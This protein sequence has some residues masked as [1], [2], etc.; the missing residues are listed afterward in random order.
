VS[1]RILKE[2]VIRDTIRSVAITRKIHD[3]YSISTLSLMTREKVF[4]REIAGSVEAMDVVR[5]ILKFLSCF[6][7]N[8]WN[9]QNFISI[10]STFL[11]IKGYSSKFGLNSCGKNSYFVN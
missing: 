7:F 8:Y 3:S 11:S 4:A 1:V 10:F 9:W 6:Q 2:W 5:D